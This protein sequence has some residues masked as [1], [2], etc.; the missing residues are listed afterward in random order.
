MMVHELVVGL[1]ATTGVLFW[2]EAQEWRAASLSLCAYK[3]GATR[4]CLDRPRM[5][6]L[7]AEF[8]CQG[9]ILDDAHAKV[10]RQ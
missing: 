5:A 4:C 9:Q 1:V 2:N 8:R 3:M 6:C 7:T 10:R